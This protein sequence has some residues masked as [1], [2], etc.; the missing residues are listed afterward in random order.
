MS[1]LG[2]LRI[3]IDC[4]AAAKPERTGVARYCAALV[5]ELPQVLRDDD[6]V[7]LLHR[8]SRIRRHRWF[9]RVDDPRFSS[10]WLNDRGIRWAPGGLDVVHGP[11]LRIP[12]VIGAPAVST[13]HDLS[14]LDVP[15]VAGDEFRRR[16][17]AALEDVAAR[18]AQILCVS[19]FTEAALHRR[20]PGTAGRTRVVAPGI[21]SQFRPTSEREVEAMRAAR[22]MKSPYLLFVGQISARKNLP[23]L[24]DA[25]ERLH[26]ADPKL[27]LDLVLAGPVKTRGDEVVSAAESSPVAGRIRRLGFTSDRDLPALYTGAAAFVFPGKAEG[28]GMPTLE[29]MACG[30]PVVAARAAANVSTVA[31]AGVLFDPADS[32]ELAAALRRV[33]AP[34]GVRHTLI[35]RGI[36]R[37]AQFTWHETARRTVETYRAAADGRRPA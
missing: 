22:G 7:V 29:A 23:R 10:A 19:E 14:A 30:C 17:L 26:A 15:G 24:L 31:D 1:T 32:E 35:E 21:G 25:F 36:L 8:I 12:R 2:T 11:D 9:V 4:S 3:G 27:D 20:W 16:K 34:E 37:A 5:A 28:F 6:R 33:L 13:V 18:A